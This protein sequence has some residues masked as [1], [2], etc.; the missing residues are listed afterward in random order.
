MASEYTLGRELG[1]GAFGTVYE[2]SRKCALKAIDISAV[3]DHDKAARKQEWKQEVEALIRVRGH[4][5]IVEYRNSFASVDDKLWVEMEF[6]NGGTLNDYVLEKWPGRDIKHRFIVEISSGVAFLH[7]QG[8]VHRDLKPENIMI[9]IDAEQQPHIKV[10]DFGLAKVLA[11]CNYGGQQL[12]YYLSTGC[13]TEYFMAPEVYNGHYTAKTDIFSMGIIVYSM[14]PVVY[15]IPYGQGGARLLGI[16]HKNGPFGKWMFE[17]SMGIS[18]RI[19]HEGKMSQ[20]ALDLFESMISYTYHTRPSAE[21]VYTVLKSISAK[22][23]SMLAPAPAPAPTPALSLAR[24]LR[25]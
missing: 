8:V 21:Q 24:Q 17:N 6:C 16:T 20:R 23:L 10:G 13:G 2:A 1:S 19:I 22:E 12:Q 25:S 18:L 14:V 7:A 4:E 3:L 15:E 5:N 9:C 11:D